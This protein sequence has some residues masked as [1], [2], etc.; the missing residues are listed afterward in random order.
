MGGV[1]IARIFG[2][3]VRVHLS[4]VVIIAIIT[5]GIGGQ[6][7]TLNPAWPEALRWIAAGAVALLFFG[8]VVVHELAHGLEARRR[9]LGGGVVTLMFFGGATTAGQDAK[10]PSDEAAI[11]LA[12]PLAS[13]ALSALFG[14]IWQVLARVSDV[15]AEAVSESAFVLSVL[16]LLLGAINLLPVYPLDGGRIVRAV[17]WRAFRDERRA[18]SGVAI[19]GRL[20]GYTLI[21]FGFL[22]ALQNDTVNGVLLAVSGWFLTNAGRALERRAALERML[23]GVRVD[24]VMDRDLP[25]VSPQLTLDT[26]AAQYLGGSDA[27]SLPVLRG[28]DLLGLIGVSQLRRV[29]RKSWATTRASDVMIAPSLLPTLAPDDELWPAV[30]RLRKTGFDGL[31]VMQGSELLGILT[32]RGVVTAIQTRARAAGIPT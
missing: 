6:F 32:R 13:V 7:A 28:D 20:V 14:A 9:G 27:T 11:A 5:V 22:L 3:E 29:P 30:E 10:R 19:T 18:S 23:A 2:L 12:G 25:H 15:T 24:T 16:N 21:G 4:W 17:L 8:S 26:F 1:P 31:P